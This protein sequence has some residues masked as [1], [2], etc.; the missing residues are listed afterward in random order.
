MERFY[1]YIESSLPDKKGDKILYK[2]KMKTLDE[3]TQRANQLT[4]RGLTD[5]DVIS[6]LIVSEYKDIVEDYQKYEHEKKLKE[7]RRKFAIGNVVGSVIYLFM[8]VI[9]FLGISFSTKE[10]GTTW[11]MVVDGILLWVAYILTLGVNRIVDMKRVFHIFARIL[12]AM[13]VVVISVAI[14]IFMMG[15]FH[16]PDSWV[17]VFGGLFAM[18]FAD[19]SFAS[20][21]KQRLA[22]FSWLAY[23]PAM[24]T[25]LFV[26][27]GALGFL[28]WKVAWVIIPL[29]LLVDLIVIIVKIKA[30]TSYK[31]EV[32]DAWKEN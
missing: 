26:I 27:I 32:V 11:V 28:P 10:W 9:C 4:A 13:D 29:S 3:M 23:I 20:I 22:I 17:I 5:K 24:S 25:M 18:F 2:F 12:L 7:R 15:V 31:E 30:N 6:D 16:I 14:F 1:Q 21:T 19:A 8:L